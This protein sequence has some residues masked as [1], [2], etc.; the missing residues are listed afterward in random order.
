MA[1]LLRRKLLRVARCC[2]HN[3]GADLTTLD[4][5]DSD[6]AL[7]F[8]ALVV[9]TARGVDV[10]LLRFNPADCDERL[11]SVATFTS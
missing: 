8:D 1:Q 6:A 11:T 2:L 3:F 5:N 9:A 4:V 10:R 7:R